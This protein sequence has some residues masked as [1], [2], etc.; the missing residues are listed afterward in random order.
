MSVYEVVT[1]FPIKYYVAISSGSALNGSLSALT[2]IIA[3]SLR[4]NPGYAG[5]VHF[6][7]GCFIMLA[8]MIAY[9]HIQKNSKYFIYRVGQNDGVV[10]ENNTPKPTTKA[11]VKSV[12]AK[13]KWYYTSLVILTGTTTLVFP[14]YLALVVSSR[15]VLDGR[16]RNLFAGKHI[17]NFKSVL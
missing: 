16:V 10:D 1:K 4:I 3:T 14:G 13:M 17:S 12:L 7:V 11:L 9:W 6:S 5:A 2:Q 15:S 8:A